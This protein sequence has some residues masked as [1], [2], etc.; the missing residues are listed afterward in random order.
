MSSL[1]EVTLL[2]NIATKDNSYFHSFPSKFSLVYVKILGCKDDD[3][4]MRVSLA[5]LVIL[6]Q[7]YQD[8]EV[9][10]S[11]IMHKFV[12]FSSFEFLIIFFQSEELKEWLS[13]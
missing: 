6:I 7:G 10:Y 3:G 13:P 9:I 4:S 2:S 1:S 5:W 8:L 12:I 11:E